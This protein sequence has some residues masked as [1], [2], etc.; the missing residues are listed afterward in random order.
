M[1]IAP[2]FLEPIDVFDI[3]FSIKAIVMSMLGGVGT[4]MGPGHGRVDDGIP[5]G[6]PV[7]GVHGI[8]QACFW[9]SSSCWSFYS[10]R[11]A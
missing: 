9:E 5:G 4:V 1:P 11:V 10:S 6:L 2:H 7:G 3:M 8:P